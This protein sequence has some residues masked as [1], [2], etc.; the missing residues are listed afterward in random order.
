MNELAVVLVIED[1]PHTRAI[2]QVTLAQNGYHCLHAGN[3]AAGILAAFEY[4]PR[5]ILLDLGLP[6]LGGVEVTR[7]IREHNETPIIVVSA[8]GHETD[9]VA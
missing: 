3:G 6:D 4:R 2:L 7:R 9:K 5:V 1:D 8:R